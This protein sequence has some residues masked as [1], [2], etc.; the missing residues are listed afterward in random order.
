MKICY[1][2]EQNVLTNLSRSPSAQK[3]SLFVERALIFPNIE[4]FSDWSPVTKE[5]FCLVHDPIH[6]DKIL[7][8]KKPNGFGNIIKEV[9]DSLYYTT[10]SFY[11]ASQIALSENVAMSPTSGFHHASYNE[12]MGFCT[13]NGLMVS[14]VKLHQEKH[15][16]NIGIIDF[17]IHWGNGVIDI[18]RKKNISYVK[19][20][21]I[22]DQVGN[23]YDHWL[24]S[25][26][27]ELRAKFE[28]CSM[29]FYQAGADSHISDP[30]GGVLTTEQM[31]KRDR[32]VFQY[33]R[34]FNKPIVWNL[35]GG[36]Q[37]PVSKVLDIHINTLKECLSIYYNS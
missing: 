25:L 7:S 23:N 12:S 22:S 15:V 8:C 35:A 19:Y 36:Y 32:C 11:S 4:I 26:Y 34:N 30:L 20:M 16:E 31:K 21:S 17:D 28:D 29:L 3:P 1:R 9:A 24:D 33:A 13:F 5:Y 37:D 27:D 14:A 2:Q 6:V 18:L 10:G